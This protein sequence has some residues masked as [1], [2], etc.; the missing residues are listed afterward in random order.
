MGAVSVTTSIVDRV[1]SSALD[2][3]PRPLN[4]G[5]DSTQ[6]SFQ[7]VLSHV[8]DPCST[9]RLQLR[10]VAT[11]LVSL[12]ADTLTIWTW[13]V[14]FNFGQLFVAMEAIWKGKC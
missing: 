14:T 6:Q 11:A 4:I 12:T 2:N 5:T 7:F 9:Q 10:L 1:Q 8:E 3:T 13:G